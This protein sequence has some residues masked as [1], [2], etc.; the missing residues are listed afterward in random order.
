MD[1]RAHTPT[2]IDVANDNIQL[3]TV[4]SH[5]N[6]KTNQSEAEELAENSKVTYSGLSS[7]KIRKAPTTLR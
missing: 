2:K 5:G 3:P 6:T 7:H 4:K 1:D